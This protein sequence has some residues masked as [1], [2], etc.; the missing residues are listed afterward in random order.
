ME[1]QNPGGSI[2]DRISLR[3]IE[4]AEASELPPLPLTRYPPARD[5]S[6]PKP[7]LTFPL[8]PALNSPP[9]HPTPSTP[10]RPPS[11]LPYPR[12]HPYL[13]TPTLPPLP[14]P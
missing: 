11:P 2:K 13:A 8:P 7:R 14:P 4:E 6:R 12:H 9:P 3:M 1:M 10:S 5:P